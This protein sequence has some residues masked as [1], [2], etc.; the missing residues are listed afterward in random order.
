MSKRRGRVEER[1]EGRGGRE[2]NRR[3]GEEGWGIGGGKQNYVCAA[4][5]SKEEFEKRLKSRDRMDP[6]LVSL[7]T[8][9]IGAASR[10]LSVCRGSF[11]KP[12]QLL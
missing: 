9:G 11:N 6:L 2:G 5:K 7:H 10:G 1:E 3:E 4:C 8:G 12:E